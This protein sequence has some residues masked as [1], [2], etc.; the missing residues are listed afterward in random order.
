ML[1]FSIF[2]AAVVLMIPV[3]CNTLHVDFASLPPAY[4]VYHVYI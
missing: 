1:M 4:L 3:F 2:T